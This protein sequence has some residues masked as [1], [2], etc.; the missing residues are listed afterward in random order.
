MNISL[1]RSSITFYDNSNTES[2]RGKK[3]LAFI[4]ASARVF[5]F[6]LLRR[7]LLQARAWLVTA[8]GRPQESNSSPT[9]VTTIHNE[10]IPH[11]SLHPISMA[12]LPQPHCF[13]SKVRSVAVLAIVVL[14]LS[15]LYYLSVS[16][17][18]AVEAESSAT[19]GTPE[20]SAQPMPLPDRERTNEQS[21]AAL[22]ISTN[23]ITVGTG[24]FDVT[25][26][27]S[28]TVQRQ[29]HFDFSGNDTLVLIHIQKSGGSD[30]L[31]H[32]VTLKRNGIQMCSPDHS[33]KRQSAKRQYAICPKT[34][35]NVNP[36][37][38]EVW[39]V[40]EK[41]LGWVCGLHPFYTEYRS[42][43]S[44]Q[45][46]HRN[47]KKLSI[48]VNPGRNLCFIV[49]LRHPVL[50]YLSEYFHVQRG[51]SWSYRHKCGGREVTT[52]EMPPCYPGYYAGEAWENVTLTKFLS[53]EHN[54][55]N[56]RQTMMVADLESVGCFRRS[57]PTR[58]DRERLLQSAKD[59]LD[60][61]AY[62]GIT[63]YMEESALLF[64]KTFGMEFGD[65]LEQK[66]IQDLHSA[67]MLQSLWS[68]QNFYDQ[69]LQANALDMELYDYALQLFTRR[70]KAIGITIN[71]SIVDEQIKKL[72][73]NALPQRK[74]YSRLKYEIT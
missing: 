27:P 17:S 63:E 31:R 8:G 36:A 65:R 15:S 73:P 10:I 24:N 3:W 35:D 60:K 66:P 18:G 26:H 69:I 7:C 2:Y 4:A 32:L 5:H 47:P 68:N 21:T 56:N 49:V 48:K 1:Q 46:I 51:A 44:A 28:E 45:N 20:D 9:D 13:C 52:E 64:E 57:F 40:A 55:A 70:L 53:C 16:R 61:F 59:N 22:E 30:F 62:F 41:T 29:T 6:S 12:P 11:P 71:S 72:N 25:L 42:C 43:L 74:K 39:L 38:A 54:W 34:W 58:Q 14:C 33:T 37:E 19:S 67:P 50:R 23:Q